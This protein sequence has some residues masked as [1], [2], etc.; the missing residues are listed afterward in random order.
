MLNL[1]QV[2]HW[3]MESKIYYVWLIY[4][5]PFYSFIRNAI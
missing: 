5:Y 2:L 4:K 3:P 1:T